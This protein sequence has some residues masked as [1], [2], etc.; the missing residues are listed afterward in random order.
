MSEWRNW[1][2]RKV[3]GLVNIYVHG[4]SSPP[5]DTM[6]LEFR[7]L[8]LSYLPSGSVGEEAPFFPHAFLDSAPLRG[9]GRL[10]ASAD[11]KPVSLVQRRFSCKFGLAASLPPCIIITLHQHALIS[12][13]I[14]ICICILLG[15]TGGDSGL[16]PHSN[17]FLL[18]GSY[19]SSFS[20]RVAI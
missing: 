8:L 16:G 10:L 11:D 13:R 14:R 2:T 7:F 4:G 19:D 20:Q 18:G 6:I 5:S 3:E 1:Q 15:S 17:D 9:S 12:I